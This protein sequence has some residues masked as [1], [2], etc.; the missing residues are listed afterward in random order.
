MI[1]GNL[2]VGQPQT[3]SFLISSVGQAV[4]VSTSVM[5]IV[6]KQAVIANKAGFSGISDKKVIIFVFVV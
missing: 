3:I 6:G 5:C 4:A 2:L 1:S